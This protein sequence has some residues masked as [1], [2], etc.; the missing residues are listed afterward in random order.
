MP[1]E[2]I[3]LIETLIRFHLSPKQVSGWLYNKI[4]GSNSISHEYI[5]QHIWSVN[6]PNNNLHS[7]LKTVSHVPLK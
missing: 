4:M 6:T 2:T 1:L 7:H 5:Y 3:D